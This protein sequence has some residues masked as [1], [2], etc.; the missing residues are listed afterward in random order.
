[1]NF[2]IT[3]LRMS[4]LQKAKDI[5][6]NNNRGAYTIPSSRLYPFQWNWDSGFIALGQGYCDPQK[7]MDEVRS[8]FKGQWSNG[9]LP[10]INFH[11]I[12]P[13]Y[14]PGPDVWGAKDIPWRQ[15]G[16]LTSGITQPPVFAFILERMTGFLKNEIKEWND[17]LR[18]I[19]PKI[20]SFHRYLYTHRDPYNEGLIYIHHNW[21]AGTDNSPTWDEILNAIDVTGI[22]DV[23]ALRRDLK[24]VDASQRPTNENYRRYIYL[25]DL[26][27]RHRYNDDEIVKDCPFLVQDV[28]FNSLLV[29]SNFAL[30]ALANYLDIDSNEIKEWNKKTIHTINNKL[31]DKEAGFYFAYDLKNKKRIPIKTS[32]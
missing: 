1:M 19:F 7:A 28:L 2:E 27:I 21:E 20:L 16:L 17:F 4:N 29:K 32:S 13:N 31:W 10:H 23:S 18:E 11:H 8:M 24:N 3:E 26:F 9:M 15:N 30:I 12:D 5:L 25:I 14:F 6:I 22:R